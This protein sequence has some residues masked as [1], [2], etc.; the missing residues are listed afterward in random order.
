MGKLRSWVL[1]VAVLLLIAMDASAVTVTQGTAFTY[2]GQLS[3][4]GVP[5]AGQT[6][7]FTFTLY[8]ALSGGSVVGTPIQQAI[9]VGAGGLFTSDL[10]F[11]QIFS[12]TQYWLEIKVGTT[13]GNEQAL[14]ARQPINAVPVAQYALNTPAGTFAEFYHT[15]AG[16]TVAVA[17]GAAIPFP[18]TAL[19]SGAPIY[20][21]AQ[22]PD[23]FTTQFQVPITGIYEVSFEISTTDAGG[24]ALTLTV[25]G[26]TVPH[27]QT[28]QGTKTQ[29]GKFLVPMNAGDVLSL[30]NSDL[31][32]LHLG[33]FAVGATDANLVIKLLH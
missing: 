23:F 12:G 5:S 11:G 32:T 21:I 3:A 13:I 9:L 1:I 14:A 33:G 22:P 4:N 31:F 6:Y 2:Q 30:I 27:A 15:Y 7:Q 17:T 19:L 18:I 20:A 24:N 26:L 16:S 25:N 29:V 8:D 28:N 10:D